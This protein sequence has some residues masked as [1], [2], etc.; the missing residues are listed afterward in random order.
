MK[1]IQVEKH[2]YETMYE[3]NDGT[4]FYSEDACLKHEQSYDTIIRKMADDIPSVSTDAYNLF[5]PA[6]DTPIKI[7]YPR[8]LDDI[9]VLNEY[10]KHITKENDLHFTTEDVEKFIVVE[11]GYEWI[12]HLGSVEEVIESFKNEL[13]NMEKKLKDKLFPQ[14]K[15]Q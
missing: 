13:M 11:D 12:H 10:R 4:R 15:T 5:A 8:S 6:N 2:V 14:E 7:I 1:K 3:A 9:K